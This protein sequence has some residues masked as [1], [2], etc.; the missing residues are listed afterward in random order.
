MIFR[1][2]WGSLWILICFCS[3]LVLVF[4]PPRDAQGSL[5]VAFFAWFPQQPQTRF[6]AIGAFIGVM[7]WIMVVGFWNR[8]AVE[9]AQNE[10][11]ED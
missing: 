6:M 8:L 11:P 4:G 5:L 9:Q 2:R 3:F 10:P 7:K 1:K